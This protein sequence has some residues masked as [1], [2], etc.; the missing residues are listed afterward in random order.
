MGLSSKRTKINRLRWGDNHA[1]ISHITSNQ[2]YDFDRVVDDINQLIENLP[3]NFVAPIEYEKVTPKVQEA[4]EQ[5]GLLNSYTW[6][7]ASDIDFLID[8]PFHDELDGPT[9]VLEGL[10]RIRVDNYQVENNIGLTKTT[11]I[12]FERG[13]GEFT[14][15]PET[16]GLNDIMNND[17]LRGR[18]GLSSFTDMFYSQF[19]QLQALDEAFEGVDFEDY[20][21]HLVTRGNITHTPDHWLNGVSAIL[22]T[23]GAVSFISLFTGNN[24]LTKEILTEE[25]QSEA[26]FNAAVNIGM[27]GISVLSGGLGAK[28]Q[29]GRAVVR[30]GGR[31]LFRD[32]VSSMAGGTAGLVTAGVLDEFGAPTWLQIPAAAGVSYF[33]GA[34]TSRAIDNRMPNINVRHNVE[35]PSVFGNMSPE[36]A[37]RYNQ[38]WTNVQNGTHLPSGVTADDWV[39]MNLA[40]QRLGDISALNRVNGND[41]VAFRRANNLNIDSSFGG[42]N[43]PLNTI[44]LPPGTWDLGPS[45]RGFRI[46]DIAGN[47][48]GR[49]FPVIDR[50]DG[51]GVITSIK[52]YD[53]TMPSKQ[54]RNLEYGIRADIRSVANF[55]GV[56]RIDI[57]I[58][59]G[60]Q[61]QIVVP[62]VTLTPSQIQSINNAIEYGQQYGVT[63]IITIG[64]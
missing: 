47:N 11:K 38:H 28:A 49:N 16:I 50:M 23:I 21:T 26:G 56:G 6:K 33:T 2:S 29:G 41:L 39:R 44:D 46:D 10:E 5:L 13:V 58:V 19:E 8:Q 54:G 45:P 7:S 42:L 53:L 9:G 55:D 22:D 30:A 59:T 52:S 40:N 62:N 25:E 12:Q 63:I 35:S 1:S 48:L 64:R 18:A 3:G 20:I 24:F 31:A 36:D 32:I 60:R 37:A 15:V 57:D 27:L 61:L 17:I 34:R 4:F 43:A 51:N 14:T